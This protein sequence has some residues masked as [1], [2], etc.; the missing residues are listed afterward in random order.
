M[1]A[2]VKVSP[3]DLERQVPKVAMSLEEVYWSFGGA[4]DLVESLREIGA[5]CG[6]RAGRR[7]LFTSADVATVCAEFFAGK[8]DDQLERVRG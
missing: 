6:K 3:K 5:L 4:K 7:L 1:M 8:Y 2:A